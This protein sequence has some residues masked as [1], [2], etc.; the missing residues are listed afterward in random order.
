M[1]VEA[2]ILDEFVLPEENGNGS[3]LKGDDHGKE[4]DDDHVLK[5]DSAPEVEGSGSSQPIVSKEKPTGSEWRRYN[6]KK[7]TPKEVFGQR[8]TEKSGKMYSSTE[9]S[10]GSGDVSKCDRRN[11]EDS[12]FTDTTPKSS[13]VKKM[14]V[15]DADG[16]ELEETLL[17]KKTVKR[18]L[19][20]DESEHSEMSTPEKIAKKMGNAVLYNENE[21]NVE[22]QT[23]EEIYGN[24]NDDV[25]AGSSK[26]K[27]GDVIEGHVKMSLETDRRETSKEEEVDMFSNDEIESDTG[28]KDPDRTFTGDHFSLREEPEKP[29]GFFGRKNDNLSVGTDDTFKVPF[30]VNRVTP[31]KGY[32][33]GRKK[34]VKCPEMEREKKARAELAKEME[35]EKKARAELGKGECSSTVSNNNGEDKETVGTDGNGEKKSCDKEVSGRNLPR[36]CRK[37]TSYAEKSFY[38]CREDS[39]LSN[40]GNFSPVKKVPERKRAKSPARKIVTKGTIWPP[41]SSAILSEYRS[42]RVPRDMWPRNKYITPPLYHE[43]GLSERERLYCQPDSTTSDI[44]MDVSE[45][46]VVRSRFWMC[47]YMLILCLCLGIIALIVYLYFDAICGIFDCESFSLSDVIDSWM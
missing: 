17:Q 42:R 15:H 26:E 23:E 9:V 28:M 47:W 12:N 36:K 13:I 39:M 1:T 40:D 22:I 27:D 19:A 2:N 20:F 18:K 4:N 25:S 14:L 29:Q 10:Q 34:S 5:T 45:E 16:S 37:T 24:G 46:H 21:N 32:G 43:Y 30:D 41:K 38:V 7:K 44:K 33:T 31:K 11:I 6:V 8:L 3:D 35:K